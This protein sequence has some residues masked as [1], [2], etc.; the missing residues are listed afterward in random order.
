MDQK[1]DNNRDTTVE[2]DGQDDSVKAY[3]FVFRLDVS[4]INHFQRIIILLP[5]QT[6]KGHV[7]SY[8]MEMKSINTALSL[9]ELFMSTQSSSPALNLD[10]QTR[11]WPWSR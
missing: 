6:Q 8:S 2:I 5:L 4:I 7:A 11:I 9:A 3:M 10:L 1:E